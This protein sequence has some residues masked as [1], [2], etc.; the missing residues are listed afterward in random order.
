[1]VLPPHFGEIDIIL[2]R[3]TEHRRD[4]DLTRF[5]DSVTGEKIHHFAEGLDRVDRQPVDQRTF[6]GIG[7]RQDQAVQIPAPGGG[8]NRQHSTDRLDAAIEGQLAHQ[9]ET[10][11]NAPRAPGRL[12]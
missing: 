12:P 9:E 2:N 10:V 7:G 5:Q 11:K 1:M 6:L 3:P 4:I 8:S